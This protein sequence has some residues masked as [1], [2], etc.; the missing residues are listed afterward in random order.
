MVIV[1]VKFL[2]GVGI[3]YQAFLDPKIFNYAL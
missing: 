3:I 1:V 2:S